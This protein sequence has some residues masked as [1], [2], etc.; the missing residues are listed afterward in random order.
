VYNNSKVFSLDTARISGKIDL[1]MRLPLRVL[2]RRRGG[3][4]DAHG[5][6]SRRA[7][8]LLSLRVQR[9]DACWR[10]APTIADAGK[11]PATDLGRCVVFVDSRRGQATARSAP[12]ATGASALSIKLRARS[13]RAESGSLPTPR[14]LCISAASRLPSSTDQARSAISRALTSR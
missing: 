8:R 5:E 14:L 9:G 11:G 2:A 4:R 3:A 6:T 10:C 13:V 1:A 7:R 12:V